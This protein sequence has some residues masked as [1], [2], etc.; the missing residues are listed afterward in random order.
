MMSYIAGVGADASDFF[1]RNNRHF[2]VV[3]NEPPQHLVHFCHYVIEVEHGG[4]HRLFAADAE[5]A[6]WGINRGA[7]LSFEAT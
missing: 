4:L 7:G 6:L 1:P 5:C 3:V 2:D